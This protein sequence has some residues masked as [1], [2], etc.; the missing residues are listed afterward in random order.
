[1]LHGLER[2]VSPPRVTEDADVVADVRIRPPVLPRLVEGL[3]SQGLDFTGVSQDGLAHRMSRGDVIVDVLAP[4]GLGKRT[5]LTTLPGGSTLQVAGGTFALSRTER[6]G[7]QTEARLGEIPRPDLAGALVIKA[8]AALVDSGTRG[9][10]RHL[11]DLVFLLSLVSDPVAVRE[12]LGPN[13]IKRLGRVSGIKSP[14]AWPWLEL[15]S[16]AADDGRR[17]YSIIAGHRFRR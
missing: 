2:G 14:D 16:S 1:M 8:A 6:I 12:Q 9:R 5:D 3:R 7:V 13:N 17:A 15:S 11:V 10:D 4:D